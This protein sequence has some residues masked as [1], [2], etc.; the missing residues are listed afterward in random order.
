MQ[1]FYSTLG[2]VF[3][4]IES[5]QTETGDLLLLASH[6][7][8]HYDGDAL[9][10]RLAEEPFKSA[11]A[12]AWRGSTLE[13]FLAHYVGNRALADALIHLTS[14]PLNTDDRTVIEFAFARSVKLAHG[15]QIANLRTSAAGARADRPEFINGE[16]DW[17]LVDEERLSMYP[18][19][20]AAAKFQ[21]TLIP[22][23]KSRA[24]AFVSYSDGDLPA[25][26]RQWREQSQ[27]PKT[28]AQ[29]RLVS[30]CLASQGDG[31]AVPLIEKLA[32]TSPRDAEAIRAEYLW[33]DRRPQEATETLASFFRGL[34]EDPWPSRELISRSMARAEAI[35]KSDRSKIASGLLYDALTTPF[36]VFA[37]ESER[38]ATRLNIGIYLDDD[39][40][41]EHA[42]AVLQAFEPY[43]VWQRNFLNT[44][45]ECYLS[46]HS[47]LA[48]QADRDFDEFM[49]REAV[50]TDVS[51]L[52][53]EIEARSVHTDGQRR[54]PK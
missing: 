10:T 20:S 33:R 43:V 24:A 3:A 29:L 5:W 50:T 44:R 28:L 19:L 53:K 4:N 14:N 34:R 54:I 12:A 7:P 21:E 25:A 51:G 13:S 9:R 37:S 2:S 23:Q 26:L 48:K 40:P 39:R 11:L 31:A 15:F 38:L 18:S 16:V 27:E 45:K 49:K 42:L 30:E 35:A 36:C 41:G 6:E 1:I 17:A 46:Q 52:T 32:E 8:V 47:P 22:E